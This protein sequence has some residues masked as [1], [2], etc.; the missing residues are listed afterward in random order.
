M[1]G[2]YLKIIRLSFNFYKLK[3][4]FKIIT[5]SSLKKYFGK[6]LNGAAALIA[7]PAL[8]SRALIFDYFK[9]LHFFTDPSLL[10]VNAI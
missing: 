8:S 5:I 4:K 10:R 2:K 6:G 1:A 9:I 7:A 3:L